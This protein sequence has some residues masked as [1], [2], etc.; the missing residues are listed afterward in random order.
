MIECNNLTIVAASDIKIKETL[1]ALLLSRKLLNP[2]ETI[3]FTSKFTE[4][5]NIKESSINIT[6]I[7]PINSLK[8]YS[9]FI[10]Y[11]LYKYISTSH[12]LIIQWDG[13]ICNINKW[14]QKFLN[15]DYIG[16][17]FI[18]RIMDNK[19]STDKDGGFYTVG[20]GGFSLRSKKL[21]KSASKFK[22]RD[23]KFFTNYHEDGFYSVLHRKFLESKGFKWA[24]FEIAQ[25]FSIETPLSFDDFKELPF[26]FHGKKMLLVVKLK[27]FFDQ[28]FSFFHIKF[29]F[30]F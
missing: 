9:C 6:R 22:L 19:Y 23:D 10:V 17:P 27:K 24:P 16:A 3:F 20:N 5:N 2:A 4:I 21:L 1:Y 15:Y 29:L 13:F 8:D 18:P 11:S 14:D 7:D 12:V 26:G 28:I 25:N 30:G